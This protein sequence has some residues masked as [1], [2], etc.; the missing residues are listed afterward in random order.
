MPQ[1]HSS[2]A[3][4]RRD[5]SRLIASISKN[6][7]IQT[8][9]PFSE[10]LAH[11]SPIYAAALQDHF[12]RSLSLAHPPP[13]PTV[14]KKAG[15]KPILSH[16]QRL[17]A[18]WNNEIQR[19]QKFLFKKQ[20]DSIS[21]LDITS[22]DDDK[23]RVL[24]PSP[25]PLSLAQKLGLVERPPDRLTPSQWESVKTASQTRA[26]HSCPICQERFTHQDQV[27]L[28]CSHVYHRS[29]LESYEKYARTKSCPMCRQGNY[30]KRLSFHGRRVYQSQCAIK[31]VSSRS[32]NRIQKTW[33]MWTE[34]KKYLEHCRLNPPKDPK[35]RNKYHLNKASLRFQILRQSV[36]RIFHLVA[37]TSGSRYTRCESISARIR[38]RAGCLASEA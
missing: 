26:D 28:S 20:A 38:S 30:E 1:N 10:K 25:K 18:K 3:P 34:R 14:T 6:P 17:L 7:S 22:T 8:F 2:N 12:V 31:Y 27:L 36:D 21:T 9:S 5:Q 33:R 13:R 24:D 37:G 15:Y 11:S 16:Q 29:C 4:K 32:C 19:K 35:L 23:E